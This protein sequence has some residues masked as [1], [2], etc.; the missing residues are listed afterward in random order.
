MGGELKSWAVPKDPSLFSQDKRL[1]VQ[2]EDH[3]VDLHLQS[4]HPPGRDI[5]LSAYIR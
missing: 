1:A 5:C 3:P 4:Q 2:V